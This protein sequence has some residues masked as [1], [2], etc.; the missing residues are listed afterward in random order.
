MERSEDEEEN[1]MRRQRGG[2]TI[3]KNALIVCRDA[4]VRA[5]GTSQVTKLVFLLSIWL[6]VDLEV[7]SGDS[8]VLEKEEFLLALSSINVMGATTTTALRRDLRKK[9]KKANY[10]RK[11]KRSKNK[12]GRVKERKDIVPGKCTD[13][14]RSLE[15]QDTQR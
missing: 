5:T 4:H 10:K 14:S 6:V 13:S 1:G 7:L 9:E 3:L 11:V 15:D 12:R 8:N 2:L